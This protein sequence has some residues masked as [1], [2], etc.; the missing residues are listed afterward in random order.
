MG[1][2]SGAATPV[3]KHMFRSGT[4]SLIRDFARHRHKRYPGIRFVG[5]PTIF[6]ILSHP[7]REIRAP[8][9]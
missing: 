8:P 9:K 7:L 5:I 6:R 1:K 4:V 3:F 2:K